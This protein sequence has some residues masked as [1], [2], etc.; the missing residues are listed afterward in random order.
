MTRKQLKLFISTL[1]YDSISANEQR[2]GGESAYQ[3]RTTNHQILM[4]DDFLL[5]LLSMLSFH[6]C[7]QNVGKLTIK[8]GNENN[9]GVGADVGE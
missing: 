7:R 9:D 6:Q 3:K 8:E 5:M 1:Q 2:R 4:S